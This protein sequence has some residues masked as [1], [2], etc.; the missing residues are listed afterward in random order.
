MSVNPSVR[1]A[2]QAAWRRLRSTVASQYSKGRF[3][4]IGDERNRADAASFEELEAVLRGMGRVAV[5][6]VA[7]S[8]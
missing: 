5:S 1:T 8:H 3:V 6:R 4:A 2:N 7:V